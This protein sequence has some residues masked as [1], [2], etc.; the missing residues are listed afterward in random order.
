MKSRS[1]KVLFAMSA[2][3]LIACGS[4]SASAFTLIGDSVVASLHPLWNSGEIITQFASPQVVNNPGTE[5][6]GGLFTPNAAGFDLPTQLINSFAMDIDVFAWGFRIT[7]SHVDGSNTGFESF[8][9]PVL[10]VDLSDLNPSDGATIKG[11]SQTSGRS[12]P[13]TSAFVSSPSSVSI[14]FRAF[15]VD[16]AGPLPNTYDFE[17]HTPEPS[18][19]SALLGVG[20]CAGCRFRRQRN[21][22]R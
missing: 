5:F 12:S 15:G 19:L 1:R 16:L 14:D 10:R 4:S 22:H 7:V 3:T 13:I 17:L 2:W 11:I 9:G 18:A 6:T 8:I 20:I 21:V